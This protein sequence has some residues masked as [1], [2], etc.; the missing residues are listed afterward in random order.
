[1]PSSCRRNTKSSKPHGK[2][3]IKRSLGSL[4]W[5]DW[6]VLPC[7]REDA[8]F[9]KWSLS[10]ERSLEIV[11][12]IL[13]SHD[14]SDVRVEFIEDQTSWCADDD[15]AQETGVFDR[16]VIQSPSMSG[17]SL[18]LEENSESSGTLGGFFELK[19]PGS[20]EP[21]VVAVTCFHVLNPTEKGKTAA[22]KTRIRQWRKER[23]QPDDQETSDLTVYHPSP[24]AIQ[25]K[26]GVLKKQVADIQSPRYILW[27]ELATNDRPLRKGDRMMYEGDKQQL[28]SCKALLKE[29]EDFDGAR[30]PVLTVASI[31]FLP[32]MIRR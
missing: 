29:P 10:I 21:K 2:E 15:E 1:M 8:V 4:P 14:L 26:A 30:P 12:E 6:N 17:Q 24:R 11:N 22:T 3:Q 7:Q 20:Q 31:V 16:R 27:D 28:L 5:K 23:I 9:H 25:E 32:T 13:K 19:L 18:S